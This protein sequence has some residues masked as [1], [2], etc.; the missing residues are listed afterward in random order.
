MQKGGNICNKFIISRQQR[1]SLYRT[2]TADNK[3]TAIV[4]RASLIYNKVVAGVS[5]ALESE[6]TGWKIDDQ[7]IGENQ[8]IIPTSILPSIETT[9]SESNTEIWDYNIPPAHETYDGEGLTPSKN[10]VGCVTTDSLGR[11]FT[12]SSWLTSNDEYVLL[13][14]CFDDNGLVAT[15]QPDM[16]LIAATSLKRTVIPIA[17]GI[18]QNG[19]STVIQTLCKCKN[20]LNSS[21]IANVQIVLFEN[22]LSGS[23]FT[24]CDILGYYGTNIKIDDDLLPIVAASWNSYSSQMG[25]AW[26]DTSNSSTSI[27]C[28]EGTATSTTY[29]P[30]TWE[31][32]WLGLTC[33]ENTWFL[34][35]RYSDQSV[36]VKYGSTLASLNSEK[37]ISLQP[38]E[39]QYPT[40]LINGFC[41][42]QNYKNIAISYYVSS[43]NKYIVRIKDWYVNEYHHIELPVT[44]TELPVIVPGIEYLYVLY[45]YNSSSSSSIVGAYDLEKHEL[46]AYTIKLPHAQLT[47]GLYN[48]NLYI[49]SVYRATS[50]TRSGYVII[51]NYL[52]EATSIGHRVPSTAPLTTLINLTHESGA[53]LQIVCNDSSEP[54]NLFD[55]NGNRLYRAD[56]G[57]SYVS[58]KETDYSLPEDNLDSNRP[59]LHIASNNT[60]SLIYKEA[61]AF[62]NGT[63]WAYDG[64]LEYYILSSKDGKFV[65]L[66]AKFDSSPIACIAG[67]DIIADLQYP[68][69]DSSSQSQ[70]SYIAVGFLNG[71]TR[72]PSSSSSDT[73]MFLAPAVQEWQF[74][75]GKNTDSNLA[76]E[77]E[78]GSKPYILKV[79]NATYS[80][81]DEAYL[82]PLALGI[83]SEET[84]CKF[85]DNSGV[86]GIIDRKYLVHFQ[87]KTASNTTVGFVLDYGNYL[88]IGN[89]WA[90]GWDRANSAKVNPYAAE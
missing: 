86:K 63:A 29:S 5:K 85:K 14:K 72:Q 81:S 24:P 49:G 65:A 53:K 68:E 73:V 78:C 6:N 45:P 55:K 56:L 36:R 18:I 80:I 54:M 77:Y 59:S 43:V 27:K 1:E 8:T 4:N 40:P 38:I 76:I 22:T 13:L 41:F 25:Y 31:T 47:A 46:S 20:C 58:S 60:N 79:N 30:S 87:D 82:T 12:C 67:G 66:W 69:L 52:T 28:Y 9:S 42:D 48:K 32:D 90:I 15:A 21:N 10:T 62:T 74:Y 75:G 61:E 2:V 64:D 71:T 17:C 23:T 3:L 7:F 50:R 19:T 88:Y 57:I 35:Y 26:I 51:D 89:N 83:S 16:G 44:W 37:T 34:G 39:G 11:V 84:I 70:I 33:S